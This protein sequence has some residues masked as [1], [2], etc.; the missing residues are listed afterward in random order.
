MNIP[1]SRAFPNELKYC[2][3]YYLLNVWYKLERFRVKLYLHA[4][5]RETN[6]MAELDW[7]HVAKKYGEM[8]LSQ[9]E[10]FG[11]IL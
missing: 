3:P 2:I 5:R 9:I 10:I 6:K 1:K 4:S 7:I 8:K 11:T